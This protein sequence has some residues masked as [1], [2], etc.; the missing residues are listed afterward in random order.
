MQATNRCDPISEKDAG[1]QIARWDMRSLVKQAV[2]GI[3]ILLTAVPAL[4]AVPRLINYQG[5]VTGTEGPLNGLYT[6]TFCIYADS[7]SMDVLWEEE[8]VGVN[9]DDGLLYAIL[10]R[11]TPIPEALFSE[12]ERWMGVTVGS[13]QEIAPRMRIT[14]TPWALRASVADSAIVVSG[15]SSMAL[16]FTGNYATSGVVFS[17]CNDGDGTGISGS[18]SAGDGIGVHGSAAGPDGIG[19][20]GEATD[21]GEGLH[22]GGY[23]TAA[24]D[25]GV[26]L[27]AEAPF[28][29]W[30]GDFKG[31]VRVR[32][33][34]TG[35]T[36][37]ELGEGL[38]YAEGFDV[39]SLDNAGP[40]CVMVIDEANPGKLAIST[41][42]YDSRVA[43]I[44]AGANGLGSGVR[45]GPDSF[46]LDVALAGRVYC[47]VVALEDDIVPGDLLTTSDVPG[48]AMK[49]S[50]MNRAHGAVLG[51]AMERLERGKRAKILVLVTLQ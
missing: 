17:I 26:G 12:E 8:H 47:N 23:F 42:A 48:Y 18:S 20:L 46:D 1:H 49:V 4:S 35:F 36:V 30:A 22:Y 10:G 19:V 5:V 45:L 34:F 24:G 13:D 31:H 32:S 40:G 7:L 15:S 29:G 33:V 28:S 11:F 38:D 51:K 16:P 27:Y 25:N 21:A 9:I 2:F 43:G 41:R 6:V 50:D 37:I 3:I 14:A 39:S 44:V